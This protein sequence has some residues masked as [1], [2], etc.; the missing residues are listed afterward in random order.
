[1]VNFYRDV[2]SLEIDWE[3]SDSYAE[4]KHEE[5]RFSMFQREQLPSIL[6]QEPSFPSEL[7]ALLS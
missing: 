2:V 1:M 3:G 5:I 4:F 6:G 7:T